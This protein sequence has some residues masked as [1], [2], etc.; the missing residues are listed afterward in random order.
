[1]KFPQGMLR[2]GHL[3]CPYSINDVARMR[4]AFNS[5]PGQ[6]RYKRFII[7]TCANV[8]P[9]LLMLGRAQSISLDSLIACW[10]AR[11]RRLT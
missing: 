11:S 2:L 5:K 7:K 4:S 1:M 10:P 9:D 8:K 6:A 3:A